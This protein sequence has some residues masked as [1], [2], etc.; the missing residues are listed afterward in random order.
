[1]SCYRGN[2]VVQEGGRVKLTPGADPYI[3]NLPEGVNDDDD[4]DFVAAI[5]GESSQ[6]VGVKRMLL[7]LQ[8]ECWS[9][10]WRVPTSVPEAVELA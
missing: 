7:E 10:K 1:M 2:P 4:S 5:G 8:D 3:D 6:R 9:K